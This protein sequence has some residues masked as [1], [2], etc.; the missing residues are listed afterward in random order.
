MP[1]NANELLEVACNKLRTII[2]DDAWLRF[3]IFFLGA[4]E[5]YF[6]VNFPHRFAQIPMHEEATE[7]IQDAAQ[8]IE[9]AA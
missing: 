4:C 6:N 8:V 2:R 5:N 3:R 1:E 7:P 9:R